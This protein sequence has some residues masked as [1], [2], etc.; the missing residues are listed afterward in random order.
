MGLNHWVSG[1][2]AMSYPL[3]SVFNGYV[4]LKFMVMFNV[5]DYLGSVL[6]AAF[7]YP[8]ILNLTYF[9]VNYLEQ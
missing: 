5:A 8:A 6:S 4:C 2:V 9:T 7:M 3:L 1:I